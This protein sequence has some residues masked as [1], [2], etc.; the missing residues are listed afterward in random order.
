[1]WYE[2]TSVWKL[3][4]LLYSIVD[5]LTCLVLSVHRPVRSQLT[6]NRRA[7]L[8]ST[9]SATRKLHAQVVLHTHVSDTRKL[10]GEH[11]DTVLMQV[12][13]LSGRTT[14]EGWRGG[15]KG[16]DERIPPSNEEA[17]ALPPQKRR[18]R[19]APQQ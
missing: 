13:F 8:V 2:Y 15:D 9:F 12:F 4:P 11:A 14:G 19:E 10:C 16:G 17:A 18:T 6:W 5:G 1:M 7:A 3:M